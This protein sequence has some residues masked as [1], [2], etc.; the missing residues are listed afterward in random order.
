MHNK[1]AGAGEAF[2]TGG[3]I[4]TTIAKRE[5]SKRQSVCGSRRPAYA[6]PLPRPDRGALQHLELRISSDRYHGCVAAASLAGDGSAK[7][8]EVGRRLGHCPMCIDRCR[9]QGR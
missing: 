9:M 6:L 8:L 4:Y 3:G 7:A 1:V 5:E 2:Y